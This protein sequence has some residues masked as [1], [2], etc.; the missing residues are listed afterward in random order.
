[1]KITVPSRNRRGTGFFVAPGLLLTCAHVVYDAPEQK[2][3]VFWPK[4]KTTH[5]ATVCGIPSNIPSEFKAFDVALLKIEEPIPE[6]L[7]VYLDAATTPGDEDIKSNDLF[8]SY[9][10]L[11][12][13]PSGAG[14]T[15]ESEWFTGDDPPLIKFKD[16][17]IQGGL[18]G[19]ALLN[20]RTGRICG[21]VKETRSKIFPEGGGAVPISVAY[22]QFLHL[23][24]LNKLQ[25]D[26]HQRNDTWR[27]L[28][29]L[30]SIARRLNRDVTQF[31]G[32]TETT[33]STKKMDI[34][35]YSVF[36]P[37]CD[38]GYG[39]CWKDWFSNQTN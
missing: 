16:S 7:C 14:V 9:G 22:Q 18:S 13:Y 24:D 33:V 30:T 6:H 17:K 1:M 15:A 8:F 21:I 20:L 23:V 10:Y 38:M 27:N 39:G 2:V 31:I 25:K 35:R 36:S 19:G 29:P 32:R 37:N 12:D 3:E 11:E 26:F 5:L 28:L 34:R 4:N